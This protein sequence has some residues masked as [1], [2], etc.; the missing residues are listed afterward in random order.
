MT[1]QTMYVQF[2][3]EAMSRN[4]CCRGKAKKY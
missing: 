1:R 2:N 3:I 4:N